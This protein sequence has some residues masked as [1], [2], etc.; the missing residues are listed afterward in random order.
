MQSGRCSRP[1]RDEKVVQLYGDSES[2]KY[3]PVGNK[4]F[5]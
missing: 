2:Q 5:L 1:H 3:F 4:A